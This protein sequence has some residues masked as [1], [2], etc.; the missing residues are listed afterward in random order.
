MRQIVSREAF[1]ICTRVSLTASRR[2]EQA[3]DRVRVKVSRQMPT[4]KRSPSGRSR[5]VSPKNSADSG[6]NGPPEEPPQLTR[7]PDADPVR[8]HREYVQ[9]RLGG[10]ALPTPEAYENALEEWHRLPGAV[11]G[12][13]GEVHPDREPPDAGGA[14]MLTAAEDAEAAGQPEQ[15]EGPLPATDPG[16][17]TPY[18]NRTQ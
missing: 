11:R 4:D 5:K 1:A 16:D 2:R 8:I 14:A 3:V 13:A 7:N 9:R 17:N 6:D 10:G 18:E 15:Y 12:P